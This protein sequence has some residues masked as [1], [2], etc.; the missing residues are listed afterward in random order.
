MPTIRPI[1]YEDESFVKSHL[2]NPL[3][4]VNGDPKVAYCPGY[5]VEDLKTA[6]PDTAKNAK[7]TAMLRK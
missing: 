7:P 2:E 6:L 1:G 4:K 3:A 5:P